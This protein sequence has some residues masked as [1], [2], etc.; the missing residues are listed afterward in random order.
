MAIEIERKFLVKSHEYRSH[1]Q[2]VRII[3][4]FIKNTRESIV[5]IRIMG[6]KAS[7]AIKGSTSVATRIEYEYS[8]PLKDANEL[9][10][11]FCEKPIIDKVRYLY[12]FK[13][14]TWEIDEF[15]GNNEGLIVAEIELEHENQEF[16]KPEWLGK[17][18]T[19]EP[20]YYNANLIKFP[21]KDW[22]DK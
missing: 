21:Y 16:Q 20:K 11:N 10:E 6:D 19:G 15:H 2:D 22:P 4:G 14:F 7:F 8:I 9:L 17:E 18:V 1:S 5:R 3:Q 12:V 13:G